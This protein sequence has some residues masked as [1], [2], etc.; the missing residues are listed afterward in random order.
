V[1]NVACDVV[2][3]GSK[4]FKIKAYIKILCLSCF[5]ELGFLSG[6]AFVYLQS[7]ENATLAIYLATSQQ[8]IDQFDLILL[9]IGALP[10]AVNKNWEN[11]FVAS[12][13]NPF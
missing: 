10:T 6:G 5:H 1:T 9:N 4:I 12:L 13:K 2:K 3:Q 7:G 8:D 11:K